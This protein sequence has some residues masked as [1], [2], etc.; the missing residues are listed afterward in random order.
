M[1]KCP[2]EPYFTVLTDHRYLRANLTDDARREFFAGGETLVDFMWRTIQLR[3]SPDFAPTAILE[4]GCG[5]GRLAIPLAR[6]AARRAGTVT[7]VDRSPDMLRTAREEAAAQHADNI[8]FSEPGTLFSQTNRF[9]FLVCYLVLQRLPPSEGL[10]LVRRLLERVV[11][12]G[13]AVFQFP[14]RTTSSPL[15]DGSRWLRARLP[16]V[17][18]LANRLRGQPASRPFVPTHGYRPEDVLKVFDTAGCP[19]TY[20]TFEGHGDVESMMAFTE[21]PIA[22]TARLK[23]RAPDEDRTRSEADGTRGFSRAADSQIDVKDLIASTSI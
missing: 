16:G 22:G 11:P 21:R 4:Y 17:N 19:S 12:G 23:P 13:F 20:M 8:V 6:R 1:T 3:L 10:D 7:A 15:V 18:A 9:D 2:D 14:Y 5:A